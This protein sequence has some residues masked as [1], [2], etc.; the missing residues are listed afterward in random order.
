MEQFSD[1][2]GVSPVL[3]G[4]VDFSKYA[5]KIQSCMNFSLGLPQ[6]TNFVPLPAGIQPR[7]ASSHI[8]EMPVDRRG[9]ELETIDG[10]VYAVHPDYAPYLLVP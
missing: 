10:S 5:S 2:F 6:C 7:H 4:K 1:S 8:Q 3:F 9:W